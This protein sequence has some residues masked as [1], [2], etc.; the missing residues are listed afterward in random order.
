MAIN[1]KNKLI[2]ELEKKYNLVF[3][4][5][6]SFFQRL[7]SKKEFIPDIY[8]VKSAKEKD[9][10]KKINQ[11]KIIIV[12]SFAQKKV[13]VEKYNQSKSK[14]HVLYPHI[15]KKLNYNSDVKKEFYLV[16]KIDPSKKIILLSLS[17][18]KIND[19]LNV[20][21]ILLRLE[22]SNFMI[23]VDS[24][25][26]QYQSMKLMLDRL[27]ATDKIMLFQGYENKDELF[28]ASDI[29]ILTT[30]SKLY[31]PYVL[32]AMYYYNVVFV[33][34]SNHAKEI[35]DNFSVIHQVDDSSITFK[36]EAILQNQEELQTLQEINHTNSLNYS[37]ESR[38][39]LLETLIKND[40][41]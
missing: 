12:S 1:K 10:E 24:T 23:V 25:A 2:T 14:V 8:F 37:F 38:L 31:H 5:K 6:Q 7:F 29:F 11:A 32:K 30:T 19:L 33:P 27:N 17:D 21:K 41:N 40:L 35:V 22:S 34:Q 3:E 39:E 16:H 15:Q 13:L 26:S 9:F 20:V 36:I 28:I 4:Q 18:T